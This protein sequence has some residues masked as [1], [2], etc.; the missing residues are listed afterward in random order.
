MSTSTSSSRKNYVLTAF[1]L[2]FTD[3]ALYWGPW[4]LDRPR[5]ILL[6]RLAVHPVAGIWLG[7]ILNWTYRVGGLKKAWPVVLYWIAFGFSV[8]ALGG[9][10]TFLQWTIALGVVLKTS[11]ADTDQVDAV[12][13]PE[14][15]EGMEEA[16]GIRKLK[17]PVWPLYGAILVLLC[18][19][20]LVGIVISFDPSEFGALGM[21]FALMFVTPAFFILPGLFRFPAAK[22]VK[23]AV[24][25]VQLSVYAAMVLSWA[26]FFLRTGMF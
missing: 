23:T 5:G 19:L 20:V 14:E 6:V 22:R 16:P 7:L 10:S 12:P 8:I 26:I 9:L 21:L 1:I 2:V 17:P 11:Y 3:A 4:F 18:A 25:N 15:G 24:A 13:P